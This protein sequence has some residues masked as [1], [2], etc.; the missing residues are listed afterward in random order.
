MYYDKL[1]ELGIKIKRRSGQEK[2]K[3]PKCSDARKN[4]NDLPLSVNVT[5]G[6]YQCHHCGWKGNVRTPERK[7]ETRQYSRPSAEIIKSSQLKQN[8]IAWFKTRGI[9]ALTLSDFNVF[10]QEEWMPQ[11]Q[12]KEN[13]VCFPYMRDNTVVNI[14]YRDGRKNFK[15]FKDGELI[16]FGLHTKGDRKKAII[17]EGEIDALSVFEVGFGHELV[18]N[19]ETGEVSNPAAEYAVFSVPNGATKGNANLEYLENCFDFLIDLEEVIIATDDDE[20]GKSLRDELIRRIGIERCKIVYYPSVQCVPTTEGKRK[21]KDANEILVYLGR[22][23]LYRVIS[24]ADFIPVEGIYYVED[25]YQTMMDK[26]KK[27]VVLQPTTRFGAMDDF[28]R[29]KKGESNLWVGYGNHGK[30]F[31]VLQLMLTKSIYDGWKWGIFSPEN[32]PAGDFFDD[33]VEM[34]VGKWLN[35]MSEQ[36]YSVALEFLNHHFFYVYPED[37]HD[38]TSIHEKFRYL[39]LKKGID[40]VLVDPWNQLDHL[41]GQ[42][43]RDDQYLSVALKD[44][45]RFMLLNNVSYNI[46][47]HPK[48][49]TYNSDRS[50]SIVDMYDV[51]GGAMWGNKIYNIISYYRP[52]FHINKSDPNVKIVFQKI[53]RKRTGGQ[54]GEI[55][56][57]LLWD[58][59]RYASH[60]E[61]EIFCDPQ[62]AMVVKSQEQKEEKDLSQ[63]DGWNPIN[64][65]F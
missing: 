11:T 4:K 7:R 42:Y 44:V 20:A 29:W 32:W 25:L 37:S 2:C 33:L 65:D 10:T 59:K 55:D 40:G 63:S 12:K 8:A 34:Y 31:F 28:F 26:F 13:C 62:M 56:L 58:K 41:Q 51:A 6:Q 45:T 22:D 39:V 30:S 38:I 1:V 17:V 60:P 52:N 50:L 35:T 21:C 15:M 27:G 16:L 46:I 43:Q 24:E 61:G 49:P 54:H 5:T 47:A 64:I 53:K 23:E 48:N 9:S 19:K 18:P 14:K 36:E 3:C 57:V